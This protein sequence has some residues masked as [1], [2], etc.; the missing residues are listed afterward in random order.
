MKILIVIYDNETKYILDEI[1][2][3]DSKVLIEQYN[4]SDYREKK[5]AFPI[6]TRYGTKNVPLVVIANENLDE[7]AAVWSERNPDWKVE[8]NKLIKDV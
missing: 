2:D 1:Q 3:L 7:I 8:I 4:I 6:M 5:K